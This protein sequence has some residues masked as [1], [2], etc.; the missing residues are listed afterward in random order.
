MRQTWADWKLGLLM[1]FAYWIECEAC[2]LALSYWSEDK[3]LLALIYW[4]ECEACW[5]LAL[6]AFGD[7]LM[8]SS[9]NCTD[10][11]AIPALICIV[12]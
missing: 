3:A 6:V 11:K 2:L 5:K 12:A 8:I 1:A 4:K 7:L 9:S 10:L